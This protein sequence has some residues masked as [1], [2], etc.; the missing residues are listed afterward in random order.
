MVMAWFERGRCGSGVLRWRRN[1]QR[2]T[3]VRAPHKHTKTAICF[4]FA[5][6]AFCT[7]RVKSCQRANAREDINQ[8][9]RS[10]L[11]LAEHFFLQQ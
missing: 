4:R 6:D 10:H 9:N 5:P 2:A 3:P 8:L 1:E 11:L 7:F